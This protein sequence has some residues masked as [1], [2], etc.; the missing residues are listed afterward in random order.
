MV[1]GG[2]SM[3]GLV[4]DSYYQGNRNEYLAHYILSALGVAVKVHHEEDIGVD[5]ICTLAKKEARRL[6]FS[7]SFLVQIKSMSRDN[8]LTYGGPHE[9]TQQWQKEQINWLFGQDLPFLI[10][11]VDKTKLVLSLYITSNMW[12]V[13][14]GNERIGQVVLQPNI[15]PNTEDIIPVPSNMVMTDWPI[16]IGDGKKYEIPLGPPIAKISIDE[17]EDR[18]KVENFRA[19][20]AYFL[21]LEQQNIIYRKLNIHHA[22]FPRRI[23]TNQKL[24]TNFG[25]YT[26]AND[27]PGANIT[28]QLET[29]APIILV[30]AYNFKSQK[31]SRLN[32]L[33][34]V[35]ELL[36][37]GEEHSILRR[38]APELFD[39]PH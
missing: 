28:Q 13:F 27:E 33:K 16:G 37:L 11:L 29:L 2:A 20:L 7:S 3:P 30:L 22:K 5:F 21:I 31:D 35:V 32:K 23:T 12:S 39:D 4:L 17:T 25:V 14:Y 15:P 34:E 1:I 10:G 24:I 26:A 6:T 36:P 8:D 9:K 38:L 18:D 19:V